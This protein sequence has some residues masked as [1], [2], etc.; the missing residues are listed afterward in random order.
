MFSK[1]D[2]QYAYAARGNDRSSGRRV[3]G[4]CGGTTSHAKHII[5]CSDRLGERELALCR[6][7]LRLRFSVDPNQHIDFPWCCDF[8]PAVCGRLRILDLLSARP[9]VAD[10][11]HDPKNAG[12]DRSR[13]PD[14]SGDARQSGHATPSATFFVAGQLAVGTTSQHFNS[15]GSRYSSFEP[16]RRWQGVD[17]GAARHNPAAISAI[18][19]LKAFMNI[20]VNVNTEKLAWLVGIHFVFVISTLLL[21]WS[22]RISEHR[23]ES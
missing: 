15:G 11:D 17:C 6:C 21:A 1:L 22:D 2:L 16:F 18:Q 10:V 5:G 3:K 8:G 14:G 4:F 20:D 7:A 19:V 9:A 12:S 23:A 13:G